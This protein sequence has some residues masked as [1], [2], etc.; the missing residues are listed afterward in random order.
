MP[1]SRY[2]FGTTTAGISPQIPECMTDGISAA[3]YT[4]NAQLPSGF[5]TTVFYILKYSIT[6]I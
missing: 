4:Y 3:T 2:T 6:F 5:L 1:P